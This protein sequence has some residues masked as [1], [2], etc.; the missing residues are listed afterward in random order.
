MG[1]P[2]GRKPSE[3]GILSHSPTPPRFSRREPEVSPI[4]VKL[5]VLLANAWLA[6]LRLTFKTSGYT[7]VSVH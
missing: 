7:R 1:D 6:A 4:A 2:K 3:Q 5:S